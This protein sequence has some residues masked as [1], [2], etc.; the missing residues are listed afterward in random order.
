MLTIFQHYPLE[1]TSLGLEIQDINNGLLFLDFELLQVGHSA[2]VSMEISKNGIWL[3]KMF[4]HTIDTCNCLCLI[5][6]HTED[7]VW[8]VSA[9][10]F[11]DQNLI[12]HYLQDMI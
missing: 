2:C 7:W 9:E 6:P 3:Y 8:R 1:I 10:L 12:S 4:L 11:S 5:R